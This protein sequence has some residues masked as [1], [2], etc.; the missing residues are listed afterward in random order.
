MSNPI[1]LQLDIS[2]TTSLTTSSLLNIVQSASVDNVQPQAILAAEALGTKILFSTELY[3]PAIRALDGRE[4]LVLERLKAVIG[5]NNGNV[6]RIFRQSTPLIGFFLS[7]CALKPCF[8]DSELGDLAFQWLAKEK[9]LEKFPVASFQLCDLMRTLSGHAELL[10]P[11]N[12]M[13]ELAREIQYFGG[14]NFSLYRK[15]SSETMAEILLQIFGLLRDLSI[16]I[17]TVSGQENG[18]ILATLFC[19]MLPEDTTLL[20]EEKTIRGPERNARLKVKLLS[21]SIPVVNDWKIEGWRKEC[22]TE[23][24]IQT[25]INDGEQCS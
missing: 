24:V 15:M 2:N 11:D 4:H 13:S 7:M 5:L 22:V 14:D 25:N 18:L 6:V 12:L 16:D 23:F 21:S 17:V 9:I 19:F 20:F 8:T 3:D 10:I 1:A